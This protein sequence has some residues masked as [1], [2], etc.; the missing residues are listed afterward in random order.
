ML[1]AAHLTADA[2]LVSNH[3]A[4]RYRAA[5]LLNLTLRP[6]AFLRFFDG[7]CSGDEPMEACEA[8]RLR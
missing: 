5:G 2:R 4:Q 8:C 7:F 1:T 6:V 3:A